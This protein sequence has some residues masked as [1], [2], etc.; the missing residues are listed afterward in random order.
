[1]EKKIHERSLNGP[2]VRKSV[3]V[4]NYD[5]DLGTPWEP[6]ADDPVMTWQ[7]SRNYSELLSQLGS[8]SVR[9]RLAR[10][11]SGQRTTGQKTQDER[12]WMKETQYP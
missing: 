1:M 5:D 3:N 12:D 4:F 2:R 8:H 7:R 10:K 6:S 11:Y 9:R